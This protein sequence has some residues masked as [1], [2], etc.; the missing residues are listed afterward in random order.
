MGS[1]LTVV[2][3]ARVSFNKVSEYEGYEKDGRTQIMAEGDTKLIKYLAKHQHW[4][5][6]AH[7]Q[8]SMR[9]KVPVFLARQYFKHIVGSVK[10]EVSRR[11][12]ST[13]PEFYMPEWRKK[14][15]GSI[16]QGS[17]EPLEG[18]EYLMARGMWRTAVN[19]AQHEY[20]HLLT[21][22]VAPEQARAVLPQSMYTE[23]VD[24]GSLVYWTRMYRQRT[25]SN[26]QSEWSGLMEELDSIMSGL[27]P[28]AWKELTTCRGTTE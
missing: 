23:F 3:S 26:A 5:P 13:E 6:F 14:P 17:G 22:G 11:Y 7:P 2:N 19:T 15:D 4:T 16:K 9:V 18:T 24:T 10:N 28:V 21:I 27:F 12:I 25:E 1:D 8:I 20:Q